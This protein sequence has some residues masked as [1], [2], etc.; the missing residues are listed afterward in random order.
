[1]NP[2]E[3]NP[4]AFRLSYQLVHE[5]HLT[6]VKLSSS[7]T[8]QSRFTGCTLSSLCARFRPYLSTFS[9]VSDETFNDQGSEANMVLEDGSEQL[10][11]EQ[12]NGNADHGWKLQSG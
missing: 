2:K 12:L 7:K 3:H 11:Y 1:M 8:P 6:F 5:I 10:Y 9:Y 4:C